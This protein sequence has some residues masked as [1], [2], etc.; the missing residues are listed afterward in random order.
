MHFKDKKRVV[1]DFTAQH[2]YDS[3]NVLA[4][5]GP[6]RTIAK[7]LHVRPFL[8]KYIE[9]ACLCY[10]HHFRI[11]FP[12]HQTRNDSGLERQGIHECRHFLFKERRD[13]NRHR[14]WCPT[15]SA[16]L[17]FISFLEIL[18]EVTLPFRAYAA[19]RGIL[20]S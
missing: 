13:D 6:V 9:T 2:I 16:D 14:I 18:T 8:G 7:H 20:F 15:A 12:L 10:L 17:A 4:R 11:E 19:P 5:Y 3:G 1:V